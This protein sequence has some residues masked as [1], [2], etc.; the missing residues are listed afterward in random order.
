MVTV[1]V[2]FMIGYMMTSIFFYLMTAF[3]QKSLDFRKWTEDAR[4]IA[5]MFVTVIGWLV[6]GFMFYIYKTYG[7]Y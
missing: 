5:A 1:S 3:I 2:F 4:F 6:S 7:I